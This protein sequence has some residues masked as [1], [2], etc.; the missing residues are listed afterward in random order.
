MQKNRPRIEDEPLESPSGFARW[1]VV[2]QSLPHKSSVLSCGCGNSVSEPQLVP[3]EAASVTPREPNA[4][5][6][7]G[8]SYLWNARLV[9]LN[10]PVSRFYGVWSINDFFFWESQWG[11]RRREHLLCGD[12]TNWT[13]GYQGN[14]RIRGKLGNEDHEGLRGGFLLGYGHCREWF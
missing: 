6:G 2:G 10:H 3:G 9:G 4:I 12:L 8:S 5:W 11:S 7:D 1:S 13:R 14:L